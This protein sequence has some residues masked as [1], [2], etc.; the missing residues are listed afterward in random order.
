MAVS[1]VWGG[2]G[3]EARGYLGQIAEEPRQVVESRLWII[4]TFSTLVEQLQQLRDGEFRRG[5][6]GDCCPSECDESGYRG[7]FGEVG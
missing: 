2:E 3:G 7:G 6:R 4:T 1:V 5:E